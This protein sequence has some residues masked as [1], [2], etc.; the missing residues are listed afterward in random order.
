MAKYININ[1]ERAKNAILA[2]DMALASRL[3]EV[4]YLIAQAIAAGE[5]ENTNR[6]KYLIKIGDMI[7]AGKEL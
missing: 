2:G 4:C 5:N 1:T 7:A 6:G 3:F